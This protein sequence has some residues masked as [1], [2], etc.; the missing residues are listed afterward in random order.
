[1]ASPAFQDSDDAAQTFLDSIMACSSQTSEEVE[2]VEEAE[3][4]NYDHS[5][6]SPEIGMAREGSDE[7]TELDLGDEED[8]VDTTQPM[9]HP[10]ALEQHDD[11]TRSE[12]SADTVTSR[13]RTQQSPQGSFPR[14]GSE[15][16]D[17]Q[18]PSPFPSCPPPRR[19]ARAKGTLV[20]DQKFHPL[21]DFIRP[22]HAAKRRSLH[23]EEPAIS[24]SRDDELSEDSGSEAESMAGNTDSDEE[25]LQPP[26][27]SRKR[28]RSE[29]RASNPTRRSSRRKTNPKVSYNMKIHPQDS[30]LDRVCACDGS[31]S[32][33]SPNK[34]VGDH[35]V[36]ALGMR[37][38]Q[39]DV[40]ED[41]TGVLASTSNDS[42]SEPKVV[43][44]PLIHT[45]SG[46]EFASKQRIKPTDTASD[47][48]PDVTYLTG[49]QSSWPAMKG[50]PFCV[51]TEPIEDQLNTEAEAASPFH[52]EE[53]DK[54]NDV[55][56]P[57]LVS[58][59]SPLDGMS[60]M[61]A[62]S[63]RRSS[64]LQPI[65]SHGSM[66]SNAFYA[67]PQ[68]EGAPYGLGWSDGIHDAPNTDTHTFALPDYM[69]ILAS[70]ENLPRT[71]AHT[72]ARPPSSDAPV[73]SSPLRNF[74][75]F[76]LPR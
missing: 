74:T 71:Y 48:H 32:S 70:S 6:L 25:D 19:S 10:T 8:V 49:D 44:A 2:E 13:R 59:P 27:G 76:D 4:G 62:A 36:N 61:P 12:Q 1:M 50:L 45:Q 68:F 57:E 60:I 3:D 20:Y 51:Y 75:T 33:P 58:R 34:L 16:T 41:I 42:L 69:Q 7:V 5:P 66:V 73:N 72:E 11:D 65:A 21:D 28:K 67:H 53:D 52:F 43:P 35:A 46:S 39:N 24:N 37:G 64:A 14:A 31:N 30:D 56:N 63:Y 22:S 26:T 15:P 9:K 47:L 17:A 23:G 40:R 29:S 38:L 55:I 54:E 18:L